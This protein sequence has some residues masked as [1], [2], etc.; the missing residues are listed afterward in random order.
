MNRTRET[1]EDL[2]PNLMRYTLTYDE[3]RKRWS[4]EKDRTTRVVK[5]FETKRDATTAGVLRRAV[6]M[7][8][9]SVRIQKAN[10]RFQE[11]RTYP[12]GR[13]PRRSRG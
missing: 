4:L 2:M 6:G 5:S 9:G 11:E 3:R 13:D 7:D 1:K 12:R 8:G 10:G